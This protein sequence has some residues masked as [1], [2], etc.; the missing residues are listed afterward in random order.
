MKNKIF[1]SLIVTS[2]IFSLPLSAQFNPEELAERVKW[3]EFLKT[4]KVV[5]QTQQTGR[6]AVTNPWTLTLDKDGIT[7]KALWKNPE[8]R[9]KGSIEN[10]KWEI[11]AYLLDKYLGLNMVPPTVERRFHGDRG[12][13]QVWADYKM[14]LRTKTNE[15]I[16]TPS[17]KVF[18]WNR[19][20]YLQRAFDSLIA[21]EDRHMGNILIT[22]DWRMILIDHSRSFRSSKKHTKR[23]IYG[24]KGISGEKP[25]KQLPRKFVEKLK[26][27]DFE[28]VKGIVGEYLQDKEIQAM[29][30]RRD[31]I[32]KEIGILI[33]EMGEDT[34]L[35]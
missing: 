22:E 16:K 33:K 7:R 35:Y 31:I 11:A 17:Y 6:L 19:A 8:G 26:S 21:N 12:S 34:V 20:T 32:L 4:A 27:M 5:A 24:L 29:L 2:M 3:E 30:L 15:K 25:M 18:W 14:N 13:C 10:W 23:L 28:L 1:I 9:L